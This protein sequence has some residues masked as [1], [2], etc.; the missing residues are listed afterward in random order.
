MLSSAA[1]EAGVWLV[2]GKILLR[3][4]CGLLAD[5]E[6]IGSIPERS[7]DGKIYNSSPTFSPKGE[8]VSI[9]EILW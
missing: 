9:A 5:I 1:K 8:L 7:K 3:F 2:G 6:V 4:I